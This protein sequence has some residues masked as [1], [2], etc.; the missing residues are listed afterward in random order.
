MLT[1]VHP[2]PVWRAAFSDFRR[3]FGRD[4][5]AGA[6]LRAEQDLDTADDFARWVSRLGEVERGV[7]LGPDLVPASS[8]WVVLNGQIVGVINLRHELN[9]FL[10]EEGGH[11]G[12]AIDPSHRGRGLATA[13][14]RLMLEHARSLGINPVLVTCD[15]DNLASAQVIL[16]A[17]GVQQDVRRGK[18][19]FWISI[20]LW[21]DRLAAMAAKL[22]DG[23]QI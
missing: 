1:L 7:D 6:S 23:G 15:Q 11:I 14:L 21:E 10:L 8:R 16:K 12:Y 4:P 17:G 5:I 13:A 20:L 9:D 18:R 3:S 2:D 22:S 19:R